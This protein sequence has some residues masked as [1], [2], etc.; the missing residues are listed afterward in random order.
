MLRHVTTIKFPK[1]R[2]NILAFS[3]LQYDSS[4]TVSRLMQLLK[5]LETE[6][7]KSQIDYVFFL[8]DLVNS[9]NVLEDAISYTKLLEFL[10][11]LALAAPLIIVL[12]NHDQ[13]YYA[14]NRF[15]ARPDLYHKFCADLKQIPQVHLLGTDPEIDYPIFDDGAIRILGLNL[16]QT[17]YYKQGSTEA[18]L[19][20]GQA[21]FNKLINRY[22]PQLKSTKF[23]DYYLL[24]HS[25]RYLSSRL[26][27]HS[28]VM[29]LAGHMHH[30]VVPPVLDELTKFT[31]QG[32]VGPGLNRTGPHNT[33]FEL[34]P[35]YARLRP[36]NK[37][38]WHT[39]RPSTYFGS[40]LFKLFN[41]LY[42]K[43]SYSLILGDSRSDKLTVTEHYH[44]KS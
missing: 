11:Q 40:G 12:G 21:E 31:H 9:L 19:Q 5:Y 3:D 41:H 20:H 44:H 1:R 35:P 39:V 30:G 37:R 10:R 8:G 23:R 17:C 22:L 33:Q 26:D 15:R 43:I 7:V 34:F 16:P 36:T 29:V 27:S 18:S 6:I 24:V 38:P 42:P 32:I 2:R 4:F 13:Y 14:K 28:D 25:P